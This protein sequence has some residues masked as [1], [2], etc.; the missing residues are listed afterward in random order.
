MTSWPAPSAGTLAAALL[1]VSALAPCAPA[2]AAQTTTEGA[3]SLAPLSQAQ[4]YAPNPLH[5]ADDHVYCV[6]GSAQA[7]YVSDAFPTPP[8]RPIEL[9]RSEWSSFMKRLDPGADFASCSHNFPDKDAAYRQRDAAAT[10][11]L[12]TRALLRVTYTG[13][14]G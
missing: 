3:G 14:I 5:P 7:V 13:W 12:R 6:A 9:V 8:G 2:A 1:A 10:A 4:G 11:Q